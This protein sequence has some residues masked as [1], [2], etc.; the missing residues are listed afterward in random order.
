MSREATPRRAEAIERVI[1]ANSEGFARLLD[2][3]GTEAQ[4]R[5]DLMGFMVALWG[6]GYEEGL[7]RG[8]ALLAT[9]VVR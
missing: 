6:R 9:A 1:R 3:T 4:R 8:A 5:E 7:R 2:G